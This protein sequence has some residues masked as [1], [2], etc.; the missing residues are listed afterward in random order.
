M[1]IEAIYEHYRDLLRQ[2]NSFIGRVLKTDCFNEG[3][4]DFR[5]LNGILDPERT[6]YLE[7]DP[8]IITRAAIAHPELD[9][10]QGDIRKLPFED[11]IFNTVFDLSTI[12]HVPLSDVDSVLS[13][14]HRVLKLNGKLVLVAWCAP[15][16][17]EEPVD[18]GGLQY[19]LY[20]PDIMK[21]LGG[22]NI[23]HR[24]V[25]HRGDGIYLVEFIAR[26][27]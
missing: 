12:D 15:D 26:K 17:K 14:Y 25:I 23:Q 16:R 3:I 10:R 27:S 1:K 22:F 7:L 6:T 5:D 18:W 13:E 21:G 9:I 24:D 20:E 11:S 4:G 2:N 19:F 8:E